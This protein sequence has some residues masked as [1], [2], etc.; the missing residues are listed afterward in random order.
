[1]ERMISLERCRKILGP[2]VSV[3]DENLAALREQLYSFAE[4][5]LDI[6][7]RKQSSVLP[8]TSAF[9]QVAAEQHDPDVL[10]ER[11]A[12]IEFDGNVSRDEAERKAIDLALATE[13]IN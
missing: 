1:M 2:K 6:R 3:S 12:I 10:R 13:R 7:D 4:L 5:A 9:E 11:A 8:Y